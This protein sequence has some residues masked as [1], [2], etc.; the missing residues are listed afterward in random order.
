ML[1]SHQNGGQKRNIRKKNCLKQV[2]HHHHPLYR[3]TRRPKTSLSWSNRFDCVMDAPKFSVIYRKRKDSFQKT[4][5]LRQ[6][7]EKLFLCNQSKRRNVFK[8]RKKSVCFSN[9]HKSW[10]Q[11]QYM[12]E[13]SSL[14]TIFWKNIIFLP[15]FSVHCTPKIQLSSWN[16]QVQEIRKQNGNSSKGQIRVIGNKFRHEQVTQAINC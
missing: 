3:S 4:I 16:K 10:S 8:Y 11:A 7:L 9:S 1:Q 2:Q 14:E 5:C 13:E 6:T 15:N 12:C